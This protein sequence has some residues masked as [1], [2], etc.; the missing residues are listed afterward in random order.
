MSEED[1]SKIGR[2]EFLKMSGLAV[3]GLVY[4]NT[5]RALHNSVDAGMSKQALNCEI[6]WRAAVISAARYRR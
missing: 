5:F 2:R 1:Y 3:F 6:A 4:A